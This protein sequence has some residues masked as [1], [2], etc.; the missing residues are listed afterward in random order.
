MQQMSMNMRRPMRQIAEAI[1]I[2]RGVD[3]GP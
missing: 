2:S 3:A 1:I